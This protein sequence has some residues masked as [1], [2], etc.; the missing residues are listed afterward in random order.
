[1]KQNGRPLSRELR[2]LGRRLIGDDEHGWTDQGVFNFEGG[3]YARAIR[4]SKETEPDIYECTRR[5]G[6]VLE[7]V[8]IDPITRRLNLDDDS[9]TENTRVAYPISHIPDGELPR[10]GGSHGTFSCSPVTPSESCRQSAG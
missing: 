4:L 10:M 5:F 7:N 1:M 3:C 9:L 2:E 6:S 8:A